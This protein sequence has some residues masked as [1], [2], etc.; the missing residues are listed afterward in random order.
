MDY[1]IPTYDHDRDE[2][3]YTFF[4]DRAKWLEFLTPLFKEPGKY[5]FDETSLEFN[6]LDDFNPTNAAPFLKIS[7]DQYIVGRA[8]V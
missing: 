4:K 1:K 3:S 8:H 5:N 7:E 6:N 2:W